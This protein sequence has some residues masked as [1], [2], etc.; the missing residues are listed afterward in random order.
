M[1]FGK[2]EKMPLEGET[3]AV[4]LPQL[5][6]RTVPRRYEETRPVYIQGCAH[7]KI[8]GLGQ[9][10][11][12]K[13]VEKAENEKLQ[14]IRAAEQAVW[15]EA[16]KIK[17]VALA[18][19]QEDAA[20][21]Q[22]R[23]IKKLKKQHGKALLEEALK[24]EMA[25]Q[26]LAIEQVKQER[27]EGEER[28]RKA[29]KE[30]EERLKKELEA[31][32]ASARAEEKL[33][34]KA[35]AELVAQQNKVKFDVAMMEKRREKEEALEKLRDEKDLEK[36]NR[37]RDAEGR[38]RRIAKEKID[39]ITGQ[40]EAVI[41]GLRKDIEAKENEIRKL[42]SQLMETE[43][44]KAEVEK[45]LLDTRKDFQDFIDNLPPYHKMQADFMLPRVYLDE[46]EK[47]GYH[48]T[49]LRAPLNKPTKK[50]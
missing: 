32:V 37:V 35:E 33:A 6:S 40:F 10:L 2:A 11:H 28:L 12:R 1:I 17:A 47:K 13:E 38:E 49:P 27:L 45:C 21:E 41:A 24:V 50:K 29:V 48:I 44:Q 43:R 4:G 3:A 19:A 14:A 20:L 25:M 22:E 42:N 5:M 31:A 16:E 46:L 18:K 34:A 7:S 26:K 9:E 30:T 23:V 39:S 15:E 8:L 36:A